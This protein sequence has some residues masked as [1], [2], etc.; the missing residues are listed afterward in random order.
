MTE[1]PYQNKSNHWLSRR[2]DD[3]SRPVPA[4]VLQSTVVPGEF[5][6]NSIKQNLQKQEWIGLSSKKNLENFFSK[7]VNLTSVLLLLLL[8]LFTFLKH[9]NRLLDDLLLLLIRK[10]QLSSFDSNII[11]MTSPASKRVSTLKDWSSLRWSREG[12]GIYRHVG[13]L[14][15]HISLIERIRMDEESRWN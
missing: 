12:T 5:F 6:C 10:Q 2:R 4:K 9:F 1:S 8:L 14:S 11:T 13:Y 3:F 7:W 15:R